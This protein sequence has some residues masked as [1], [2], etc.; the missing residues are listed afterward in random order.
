MIDHDYSKIEH[1]MV[2]GEDRCSC[3]SQNLSTPEPP[4]IQNESQ[5][6]AELVI[7]DIKD[8]MAFGLQKYVVLLQ[9]NNGR[10]AGVDA[11]QEALDHLIY[12]RQ[13]IENRFL[14]LKA[15]VLEFQAAGFDIPETTGTPE[16]TFRDILRAIEEARRF[17]A[18]HAALIRERAGEVW[19]W[20]GVDDF[21]ESLSC[22]ILIQPADFLPMYRRWMEACTNITN[23]EI[24]KEGDKDTAQKSAE[25]VV[26]IWR[27]VT[28]PEFNVLRMY[29]RQCLEDTQFLN[30]IPMILFC[31]AC[32][33]QHI[34]EKEDEQEFEIRRNKW[35]ETG[36]HYGAEFKERWTNP[37]HKSH[38]CQFCKTKW[39]PA[40]VYTTGVKSVEP[41][42]NDNWIS[43]EAM[44][45][46]T[47]VEIIDDRGE[48]INKGFWN[49]PG[50]QHAFQE[51][52]AI[53]K[54][55]RPARK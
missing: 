11:Y 27:A 22:P 28:D 12:F 54:A 6:I 21:P 51:F 31:P 30:P 49:D 9:A 29:I 42:S 17:K 24:T 19:F 55:G 35:L 37:P 47:M 52:W 20:Q 14:L 4:P 41:G 53:R 16:Q 18:S 39:R 46:S 5:A 10:D 48:I 1:V 34:D 33:K 3:Q 26:S 8:R 13:L 36:Y 38:L 45:G 7:K 2:E 25:R 32:G 44:P 23:L 43:G 15:I 40:S 50:V